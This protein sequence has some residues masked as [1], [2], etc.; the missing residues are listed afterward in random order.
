M[1]AAVATLVLACLYTELAGYCMHRLLHSGRVAWLTRKHLVHHL[2]LY[3]PGMKLRSP[4]YR[5][6]ALPEGVAGIGWEWIVPS[7]VLMVGELAVLRWLGVRGVNQGIFLVASLGWSW[8]TFYAAHEAMHLSTPAIL[9]VP[10]LRGWFLH[11]R[12][13]HDVHHVAREGERFLGNYGMSFHL[14]DRVFGTYLPRVPSSSEADP[15]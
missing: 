1:I 14:F 13:L 8:L 11:A 9:R 12:R 3:G 6:R 7:A 15:S 5:D 4:V 2:E 10:T